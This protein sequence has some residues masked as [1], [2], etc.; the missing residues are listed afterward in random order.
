MASELKSAG[1]PVTAEKKSQ[2]SWLVLCKGCFTPTF[3][4]QHHDRGPYRSLELAPSKRPCVF[5]TFPAG[6]RAR[7][8]IGRH[9]HLHDSHDDFR[10]EGANVHHP[11][12]IEIAE[13]IHST[14]DLPAHRD[15]H[16]KSSLGRIG[17]THRRELV[18][19]FR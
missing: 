8:S 14:L 13:T 17:I 2:T 9:V 16:R 6:L 18:C 4:R 3:A 5:L 19:G 11:T 1:A 15:I 10:V 7:Q 12:H